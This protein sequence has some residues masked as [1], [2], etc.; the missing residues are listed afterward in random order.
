QGKFFL[1]T[2]GTKKHKIFFL[3]FSCLFVPFV[4]KKS[5]PCPLPYVYRIHYI[6]LEHTDWA[7]DPF[8]DRI[9]F[10]DPCWPCPAATLGLY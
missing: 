9:P 8:H 2:K 10:A 6:T 1:T 7:A 3:K 4:V 5:A